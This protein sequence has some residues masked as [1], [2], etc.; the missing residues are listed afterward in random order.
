LIAVPFF[1]HKINAAVLYLS[2]LNLRILSDVR[3][4]A[5]P[6]LTRVIGPQLISSCQD[7]LKRQRTIL[8]L[9]ATA[10]GVVSATEIQ[11]YAFL[12]RQETFFRNEPTF[13]EFLPY[14]FGPYSFAA[15]R[16]IETLTAYG[17]IDR[18]ATGLAITD[19]GRT[20]AKQVD[21]DTARA[22]LAISSKYGKVPLRSLLRD[23]YSRYSWYAL[24]SELRDLVPTKL[25]EANVAPPAIYTI[26]YEERSV[27]GFLDK[28]IRAGVRR[29]V[30][31][32]A[33]PISRKYGFAKRSLEGLASKVNIA[34][35]HFQ[36]L[37]ISSEKRKEVHSAAEFRKLF[38]YYE[39]EIL[40]QKAGELAKLAQLMKA[41][42]SVLVCMEKEAVDC[43][44]SRLAV[45]LAKLTGMETVH[46]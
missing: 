4:E 1:R 16:E 22:V 24:N 37:G 9:L 3:S 26:G 8:S 44:R 33:N 28:L 46:L 30:D 6:V 14:R 40:P 35:S 41:A 39:R 36:Q 19:L 31:V 12:L 7:M 5:T 15:Q 25:P 11:K 23:V 20:E 17:Y 13:Y 42:P 27:D 29:I 21:G 43:H 32:R 10:G 45:Q 34:Y 38:S 18:S 2:L